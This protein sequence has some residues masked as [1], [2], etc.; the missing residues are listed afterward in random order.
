ME[1]QYFDLLDGYVEPKH[2]EKLAVIQQIADGSLSHL[3]FS[4]LTALAVSPRN[5]L[6]Y[7]VKEHKDT[8]AMIIGEA[9]HCALLEPDEFESRY[10][11]GPNAPLNL[12]EGKNEWANFFIDL[13]VKH[14][15]SAWDFETVAK[16]GNY[17]LPAKAE[18]FARAKRELGVQVLTHEMHETA[19]FRAA[20]LRKNDAT[21]SI[22]DRITQTEMFLPSDFEIMGVPIK[23]RIDGKGEG[24]L[25]DVKNVPNA[26]YE[27]MAG[28]VYGRKLHW[29]AY[30]Y[31]EAAPSTREYYVLAVDPN[32]ETCAVMISRT[33]ID[34]AEKEIRKVLN[35][36]KAL[37]AETIM[38]PESA[39]EL[40]SQS[41]DFW[42]KSMS[43]EKGYF[44]L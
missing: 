30:I 3:S 4:A 16:T 32:G 22:L 28:L 41:Q 33:T 18:L 39:M 26:Q 20:C 19:K 37:Q 35:A 6:A 27:R 44:I 25:A 5:F 29:Q 36:W 17:K 11:C 15:G 21:K 24:I 43:N 8:D 42:L 23:G 7:K 13:S 34:Y 2:E 14:S 1:D 10:V 31:C 9:Q 40:W 38:F 12:A